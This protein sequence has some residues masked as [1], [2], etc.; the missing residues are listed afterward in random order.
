MFLTTNAHALYMEIVM[1]ATLGDH[2][3]DLFDIC[4][5]NCKKPLFQ[6]SNSPFLEVEESDEKPQ[7]MRNAEELANGLDIF[8]T[9]KA[10]SASI[11]T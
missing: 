2:W 1:S 4:I 7:V 6:R 8:K 11:L 10:G 3:M 9:V 5:A